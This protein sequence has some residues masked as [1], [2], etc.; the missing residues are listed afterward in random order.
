MIDRHYIVFWKDIHDKRQASVVKITHPPH[1]QPRGE[2]LDDLCYAALVN[3]PTCVKLK[4]KDALTGIVELPNANWAGGRIA[5]LSVG[6]GRVATLECSQ[7]N[8]R[9]HL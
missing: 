9:V 2:A 1:E 6:D 5:E 7:G 4:C 8:W 3:E